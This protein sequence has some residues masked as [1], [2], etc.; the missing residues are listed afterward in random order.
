M[1]EIESLKWAKIRREE[2]DNCRKE[3]IEQVAER[4]K[5]YYEALYEECPHEYNSYLDMA[6]DEML[7]Q[8]RYCNHI[9]D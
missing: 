9:K 4:M 6:Y 8:C 3:L 2:L 7:T 1:N 5:P